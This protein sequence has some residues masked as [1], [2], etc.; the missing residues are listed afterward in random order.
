MID[1]AQFNI[2]RAYRPAR[3]ACIINWSHSSPKEGRFLIIR[4]ILATTVPSGTTRRRRSD[5]STAWRNRT[6]EMFVG[7]E[8]KGMWS[9]TTVGLV[10]KSISG[11]T[12]TTRGVFLSASRCNRRQPDSLPELRVS[13]GGGLGF[14]PAVSSIPSRF[15][16]ERAPLPL[17][18]PSSLYFR[19]N[20]T[21]SPPRPP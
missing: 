3:W 9:A 18:L 1:M 15:R 17:T 12:V 14:G 7:E 21:R 8:A 6:G 2:A 19:A 5:A 20:S 4:T 11:A 10:E 13:R 16:A